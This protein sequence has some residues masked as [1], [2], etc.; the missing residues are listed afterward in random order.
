MMKEFAELN[1][2]FGSE[3]GSTPSENGKV[4][5]EDLPEDFDVDAGESAVFLWEEDDLQLADNLPEDTSSPAENESAEK[6]LNSHSGGVDRFSS[7]SSFLNSEFD[8]AEQAENKV[9]HSKAGNKLDPQHENPELTS[10]EQIASADCDFSDERKA[11]QQIDALAN[12][13]EIFEKPTAE[14]TGSDAEVVSCES[15]ANTESN[16][17][18]AETFSLP[19]DEVIETEANGTENHQ[20]KEVSTLELGDIMPDPIGTAEFTGELH[21][22]EAPSTDMIPKS[23]AAFEAI[24]IGEEV[25]GYKLVE[26]KG[27]E[28]PFFEIPKHLPSIPAEDTEAIVGRREHG[29]RGMFWLLFTFVIWGALLFIFISVTASLIYYKY[30]TQRLFDKSEMESGREFVLTIN[31]GDRFS[32]IVESLRN[33]HI[34][35]TYMGIDDKYLMRYLAWSN[36]NSN[37]IKAG[38]YKLNTAMSLDEIYEKLIK[39]SQDFRIT[40][41]EGKTADEIA[42]II[43]KKNDSF[44]GEEFVRLTKDPSFISRIGLNVPSLEGYLYPSTYFFGP[45]MKEQDLIRTMVKT[46]RET[47]EPKL[48]DVV[49]KDDLTFHQHI[50]MASLIEREA[51]IDSD[52]PIIASVIFNRLKKE[53]PLQ[54]DASVHFALQ[55]W[56]RPLTYADLKI[57]SPYNTYRNK[58]LPPG[59]ICNPRAASIL[60]TYQPADTDYLYYVYKGDGS[61][62]F[63]KTFEEHKAN[64]RLYRKARPEAVEGLIGATTGTASSEQGDTSD[65]KNVKKSGSASEDKSDSRESNSE[66]ASKSSHQKASSGSESKKVTEKSSSEKGSDTDS[67]SPKSSKSSS[68][69]KNVS[70]SKSTS[71]T[72]GKSG[73]SSSGSSS[74]TDKVAHSS[75]SSKTKKASD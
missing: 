41:P 13:D 20:L 68:G 52:R 10:N 57:D 69:G 19:L 71:K 75:P 47:I 58:G 60:A 16:T 2:A 14:D 51:R 48:S 26:V 27:E 59:P 33:E 23:E 25:P 34:I 63:A 8:P 36:E 7:I 74:K 64:V 61:H 18:S 9:D 11:E 29:R 54:V 46:F 6:L 31:P 3:N 66:S 30:A 73:K 12:S 35:N 53:M 1:N 32:T 62:A 17:A 49:K 37:L 72:S 67:E 55:N 70:S 15:P 24:D 42:A 45:G 39:G 22:A 50:I 44:D 40:I 56:S 21:Q 43:R 28:E 38:A 4:P 5:H 65:S